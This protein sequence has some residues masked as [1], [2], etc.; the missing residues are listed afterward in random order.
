[1]ISCLLITNLRILSDKDIYKYIYPML[2][3]ITRSKLKWIYDTVSMEDIY[4]RWAI[5]NKLSIL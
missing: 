1:M 2:S 4:N 3:G 5:Q